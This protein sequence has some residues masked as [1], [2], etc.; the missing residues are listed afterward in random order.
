MVGQIEDV[1][2]VRIETVCDEE[3]LPAV[4]QAMRQAHPY[5]EIAFHI[6]PLVNHEFLHLVPR[7]RA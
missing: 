2:E 1:A 7:S 5:E 4:L 6:I 3:H